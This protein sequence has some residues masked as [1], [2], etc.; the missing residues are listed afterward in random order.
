MD[1]KY[2]SANEAVKLVKS[3]D[4]VF[5]HGSAATPLSLV[6]SLFDRAEEVDN[7]ELVS[8]STFGKINWD[9][10]EVK[11]SF[12][13]NSLF[14][15]ANIR[16]WANEVTGDYIPV[17]LSEIPLL[18][19]SGI[20]PLDVA[21]L[22]V[23]PPDKH[24]FCTLG[25]SI[26]AALSA[27]KNAK[28]LIAQ[29]NPMMPRTHGDGQIH[30]S[31]FDALVFEEV[32]LPEINYGEKADENIMKIGRYV[33]DLIEDRAT[34]QMGIGGIPDA[35]LKCLTNHKGLGVHTEMFSD[36]LVP[37]VESGVITNEHKK[38]F[39]GKTITSF[40][41]G[42]KKVYDFVDDN[43]NVIFMDVSYVNDTAVIRQNHRMVAI[44]SAIEI[45]LTGQVC[46]D[47]IGTYQ[48]SGI[49]GQMDFMRGSSL[50]KGGKP[51]IALPSITA[52]GIS[53]IVPTLRRGAG[54][55]TTRGHVHHV[56]TEHG[57]VDLYGK[58]MEQRAR[59]LISIAHPDHKEILEKAFF[60]RFKKVF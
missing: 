17:F 43:P 28:I 32:A 54:V 6:H 56:I 5:V 59:M 60:E 55:V 36:G 15:S 41:A 40:I 48:F 38:I 35:V 27:S 10:P 22:Q 19:N 58:N 52:K 24:G 51:I 57:V 47:S 21:L 37:L 9:R 29:V 31:R 49:G 46:S 45:D 20:L 50:S 1:I 12:R 8:I 30:V 39:P 7:V 14:V 42:T 23:S 34:L 26:D 3:G 11:K 33:A 13:L 44:N 53:R 25:T 2:I 16:Q 18:F 4:R